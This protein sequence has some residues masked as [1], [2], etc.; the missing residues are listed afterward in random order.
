LKALHGGPEKLAS[1]SGAHAVMHDGLKMLDGLS[2]MEVVEVE[3]LES[4][5]AMD[6]DTGHAALEI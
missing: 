2:G 6:N 4:Q 5:G 1:E 3:P